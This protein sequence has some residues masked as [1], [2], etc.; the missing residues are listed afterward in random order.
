MAK[1]IKIFKQNVNFGGFL[2]PADFHY[3]EVGFLKELSSLTFSERIIAVYELLSGNAFKKEWLNSIK[4]CEYPATVVSVDEGLNLL[5][6]YDGKSFDYTDYIFDK[7]SLL[8]EIYS[9]IALFFSAYVDLYESGQIHFNDKV[10]IC[11]PDED[12]ALLLSLIIAKKIG[13][14]ID[15]IIV[16]TST[17]I[18]KTYDGIYFSHVVDSEIDLAISDFFEDYDYALDV[19]SVKSFVALINYLEDYDTESVFLMPSLILPYKFSRRIV[20]AILNKNEISIEKAEKLL[21]N[22]TALEIPNNFLENKDNR[23]YTKRN[24]ISL[25]QVLECIKC[26]N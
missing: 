4:D 11:V 7:S 2:L 17:R 6:L 24:T 13:L 22:E 19:V 8:T 14:P 1:K 21:Y 20:K 26:F 18:D 12:G 25:L 23:Y 10:S 5:E 3:I 16:G 9:L 15:M